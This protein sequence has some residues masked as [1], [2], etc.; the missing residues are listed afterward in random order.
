MSAVPQATWVGA[1]SSP[2]K[3]SDPGQLVDAP[4]REH[5][6]ETLAL[7]GHEGSEIAVDD[8]VAE[9]SSLHVPSPETHFGASEVAV[10]RHGSHRRT[11]LAGEGHLHEGLEGL[12]REVVV[13]VAVGQGKGADPLRVVGGEHLGDGAAGVVGHEVDPVETQLARTAR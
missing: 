8:L 2:N 1:V 9:L 4:G 13:H 10:A 11:E 3:R 12:G 6:L 5:A 7:V